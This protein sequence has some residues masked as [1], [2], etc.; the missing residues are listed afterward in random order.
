MKKI[1]LISTL[2]P[3]SLNVKILKKLNKDVDIFRL[4]MSHLTVKQLKKNIK[5]LKKNKIKNICID[6][7]GAQVRTQFIKKKVFLKKNKVIK[8]SNLDKSCKEYINLYPKFKLSSVKKNSKIKIGFDGLELKVTQKYNKFIKCKVL[9]SGYIEANKGVHFDKGIKLSPLTTKDIKAIKVAKYYEVKIFAL[10]FA[11]S[12]KDV[13]YARSFLEKND[14]LISKIES[15]K[16]FQNRKSIT[17][18]S[19]AILIDRGDL[20]RYINISKIPLAQRILIYEAKKIGKKVYVAT[21]LLETM[22]NSAEPTR[23]ES[24]DIFSS[25]ESGCSGL[26][27]AA[28]TAIGKYPVECVMFL[29]KCLNAYYSKKKLINNTNNFF[30]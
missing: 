4:N 20:S 30:K 11:N 25:L 13:K 12:S 3:S 6:T 24:N 15:R 2:G 5:F 19:D 27:L 9:K 18:L 1:K 8:L 28:E 23:A 7:E 10:S 22:I 16:G 26:V 14:Q 17:N 21:N 29:K